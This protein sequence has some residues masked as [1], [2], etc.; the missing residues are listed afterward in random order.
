MV[1]FT[2]TELQGFLKIWFPKSKNINLDTFAAVKSGLSAT[3]QEELSIIKRGHLGVPEDVMKAGAAQYATMCSGI[4]NKFMLCKQETH[5]DP[6]ACLKLNNAVRWTF[7]N[8]A[9]ENHIKKIESFEKLR[10]I[11]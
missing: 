9:Y 1:V 7:Q 11:W 6:R 10:A 5:G 2:G 4:N 8:F 3:Q